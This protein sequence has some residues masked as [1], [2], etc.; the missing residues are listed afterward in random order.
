VSY[1]DANHQNA[2]AEALAGRLADGI[3]D[4]G[5]QLEYTD[6]ISHHRINFQAQLDRYQYRNWFNEQDI[7]LVNGNHF[8]AQQQIVVIDPRKEKSLQKKLNRLTDVQLI[9][10][11]EGVNQLPDYLKT[12]LIEQQ[13]G[14]IPV[15]E[16][17]DRKGIIQFLEQKMIDA[18]A[19]ITGLVL[20]GGKSQRMGRDKGRI[21]YHG[22][23]QRAYLFEQL[24]TLCKETYL[25]CRPEQA[26]SMLLEFPVIAD[27]FMGLGPF[28]ALLSAFRQY[29][30]RAWLVIAC[31]LP[32]LDNATIQQLIAQRDPSKIATA[33]NSPI[34]E[35]PEP[36]ITIWEPKSYPILLQY[37]AQGYA[38]PRKVLIH[39]NVKLVDAQNPQALMNVNKPEEYEQV[40]AILDN[41]V[42]EE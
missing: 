26:A 22:K 13:V 39:S 40:M 15:L 3:M 21:N 1:V 18:L 10:L 25:S 41:Q 2:D 30:D 19:P 23:E 34:N 35:F 31:D 9:L 24:D 32:L 8:I 16:L 17:Q 4:F 42:G 11:E 27:T 7:V 28:G 5:A 36:L 29:P 20:A 14:Q 33:F 6:K 12:H 38:C 37:L